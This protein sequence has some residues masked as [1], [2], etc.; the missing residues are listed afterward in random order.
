MI[1]QIAPYL[2]GALIGFLIS[3]IILPREKLNTESYELKTQIQELRYQVKIDSI[4][5]KY[6]T[7]FTQFEH[8]DT[9]YRDSIL[10]DL[11]F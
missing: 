9:T 8:G 2:V 5:I 3:W 6:A 4:K 11:G 10:I 7:D 1:K